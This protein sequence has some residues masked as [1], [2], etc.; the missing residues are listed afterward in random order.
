MEVDFASRVQLMTARSYHLKLLAWLSTFC[1]S[2]SST[3]F[4]CGQIGLLKDDQLQ[5]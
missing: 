4:L 1:A 3:I 2:A 5:D